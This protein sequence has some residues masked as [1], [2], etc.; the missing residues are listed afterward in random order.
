MNLSTIVLVGIQDLD[1]QMGSILYWISYG[2]HSYCMIRIIV[3]LNV[4]IVVVC[5]PLHVHVCCMTVHDSNP[6]LLT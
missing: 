5:V 4:V 3:T 6:I 2:N 1:D